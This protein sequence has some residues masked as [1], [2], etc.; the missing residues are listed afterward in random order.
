MIDWPRVIE[1][2]DEVGTDG[3]AEVVDLFLEEVEELSGRL[4]VAANAERL[5]ADLHFLKG[6][7]LNLGFAHLA[8][9]CQHGEQA[10]RTGRAQDV[11]LGQILRAIDQSTALFLGEQSQRLA[12]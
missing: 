9:L 8:A 3:F 4:Q 5:A 6:S 10:A 2:R 11:D 7:A 12:G 1:L